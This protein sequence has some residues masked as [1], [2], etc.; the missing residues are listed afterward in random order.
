M[1][2]EEGAQILPPSPVKDKDHLA[3][4]SSDGRLLVFPVKE[5]K[6]LSGGKGVQIIGLKAE[7][8]L[9][10]AIAV[11]GAV[12]RIRGMFRNKPKELFSEEK[13]YGQRARRGATV[14]L[15]NQPMVE[16]FSDDRVA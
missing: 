14:G 7:E 4:H 3:A 13:H 9:R 12:V 11:K 16:E 8:S 15:V 10:S 1:T 5:M 2:V 6:R